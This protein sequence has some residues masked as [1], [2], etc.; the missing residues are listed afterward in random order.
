M[1]S[2]TNDASASAALSSADDPADNPPA[3][4]EQLSEELGIQRAVLASLIDL[5]ESASTKQ[6]IADVR[7]AIV[8]LKRQLGEAR[9]KGLTL[10]DPITAVTAF[11]NCC[12][13]LVPS[14]SASMNSP[15]GAGRVGGMGLH[16]FLADITTGTDT[17]FR[18]PPGP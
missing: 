4:I 17:A 11:T 14:T 6:K 16:D 13:Y 9:S 3:I 7:A 12:I 1:A 8:D 10:S 15:H 5:P 2:A 18:P